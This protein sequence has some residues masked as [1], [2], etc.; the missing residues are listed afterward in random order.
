MALFAFIGFGH[1]NNSFNFEVELDKSGFSLKDLEE[2]VAHIRMADREPNPYNP[3]KQPITSLSLDY[4]PRVDLTQD[5][6]NIVSADFESLKGVH[7][8]EIASCR[9]AL[10]SNHSVTIG[11]T[12]TLAGLLKSRSRFAEATV[13][14]N[15]ALLSVQDEIVSLPIRSDLIVLYRTQG[16]TKIAER[17]ANIIYTALE[18]ALGFEDS[19]TLNAAHM[20]ASTWL[21]LN[22]VEEAEKLSQRLVTIKSAKFGR[23]HPTTMT[24]SSLLAAVY[25]KQGRFTEAE[26]LQ[27]EILEIR[28]RMLGPENEFTWTTR[29][30]LAAIYTKLNRLEEAAAI[31]RLVVS[32]R[33]DYYGPKHDLTLTALSNLAMT[34]REQKKFDLEEKLLKIVVTG[35][36]EVLGSDHPNTLTSVQ[37][38]ATN[39]LS[40]K[41][42]EKAEPLFRK[43]VEAR[44]SRLDFGP[45][46]PSTL[47]SRNSLAWAC[48]E[49]SKIQEAKTMQLKTIK[50]GTE[51]LGESHWAVLLC[52]RHL[53]SML[54]ASGDLQGAGN[55]HSVVDST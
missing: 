15:Q 31:E 36:L 30:N 22:N 49:Q 8:A 46:H 29:L 43:M 26:H 41:L 54:Q 4:F 3:Y 45:T 23:K 18:R 24:A 20:L 12:R 38:L 13:I 10:G 42:P 11:L 21:E 52:K 19:F 16:H 50:D 25:L 53:G 40:Q 7:L 14:L 28:E 5:Y 32:F 39:Y 34:Y 6:R 37:A 51:K 44:S 27:K 35:R 48:F 1:P 9:K 17:E 2:E 33:E 47:A 55:F